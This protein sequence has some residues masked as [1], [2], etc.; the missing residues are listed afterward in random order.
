MSLRRHGSS[1]VTKTYRSVVQIEERRSGISYV[2]DYDLREIAGAAIVSSHLNV[3]GFD[4]RF[5]GFGK[6]R[7]AAVKFKRECAFQDIN[8]H[9]ESMCMKHRLV[10]G[11]EGRCEDTYL[12][13]VALRHPLDDL[14]DYGIGLGEARILP[15]CRG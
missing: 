5:A 6:K 10:T 12:L 1:P 11:F 2:K 9:R 7:R 3:R 8:S 15:R 13:F 4:N 14:S